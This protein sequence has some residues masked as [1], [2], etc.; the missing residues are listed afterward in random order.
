MNNLSFP[1]RSFQKI[2][3]KSNK[4]L[5]PNSKKT[6]G[7][8]QISRNSKLQKSQKKIAKYQRSKNQLKNNSTISKKDE[9]RKTIQE[10]SHQHHKNYHH[11]R[12]LSYGEKLVFNKKRNSKKNNKSFFIGDIKGDLEKKIGIGGF[13][14]KGGNTASKSDSKKHNFLRKLRKI[15]KS[16]SKNKGAPPGISGST[17]QIN[18]SNGGGGSKGIL[19]NG[20]GSGKFGNLGLSGLSKGSRTGYGS[21]FAK[22]YPPGQFLR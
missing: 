20:S 17:H 8:S 14:A 12:S 22:G 2:T 16:S 10:K 4:K 21:I 7:S 15:W 19:K 13:N 6:Y 1:E 11:Q 5:F 3:D 9:L 18:Y